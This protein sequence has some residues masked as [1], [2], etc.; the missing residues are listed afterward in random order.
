MRNGKEAMNL[1]YQ[2][3]MIENFYQTLMKLYINK[4]I[5][6]LLCDRSIYPLNGIN[7]F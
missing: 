7:G 4:K 6:K 2:I 1:S 5:L 3:M